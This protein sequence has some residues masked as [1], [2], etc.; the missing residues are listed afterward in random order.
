LVDEQLV[1]ALLI[2]AAHAAATL[3][4]HVGLEWNEHYMRCSFL[5][6]AHAY[7]TASLSHPLL[8]RNRSARRR[9]HDAPPAS[10]ES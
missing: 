8:A 7:G 9:A 5:D 1:D 6:R 3:A 10:P 4:G 2:A